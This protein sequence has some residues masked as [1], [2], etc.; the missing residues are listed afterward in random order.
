V[1][2]FETNKAVVGL[3]ADDGLYC[4]EHAPADATPVDID[5]A[6]RAGGE[7]VQCG[8]ALLSEQQRI[9]AAAEDRAADAAEE[10]R[11]AE[12]TGSSADRQRDAYAHERAAA[13]ANLASVGAPERVVELVTVYGAPLPVEVAR[14][15]F[16]AVMTAVEAGSVIL[17]ARDQSDW[18]ALVPAAMLPRAGD[19]DAYS[20]TQAK[21]EL[22]GL[23]R[24][25]DRHHRVA[26]LERHRRP[27]AAVIPL[28]HLPAADR[29]R[30]ATPAEQLPAP[31]PQ[32]LPP[33]AELY[34]VAIWAEAGEEPAGW[35]T[36][37]WSPNRM[38][39]RKV[40]EAYVSGDPWYPYAQVWRDGR[41]VDSYQRPQP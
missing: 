37:A 19:R 29:P 7:C 12:L 39:A 9:Q 26:V 38:D 10:L 18:A 31:R 21:V 5:G 15:R 13:A 27:V 25:A 8:R 28:Q 40:A 6:W 30:P 33:A 35:Q 16:G 23:V 32:P 4:A 17:L 34:E 36:V 3:W 1:T 14:G 20:L 2:P 41:K 22:G 24:S 11:Q